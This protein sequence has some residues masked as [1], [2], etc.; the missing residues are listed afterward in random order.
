MKQQKTEVWEPKSV[1]A[2][3]IYSE[4]AEPALHKYTQEKGEE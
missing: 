4:V 3:F 2:F 1:H